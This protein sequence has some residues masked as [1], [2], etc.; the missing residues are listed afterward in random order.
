MKEYVE[1]LDGVSA[2]GAETITQGEISVRTGNLMFLYTYG[3]LMSRGPLE[4]Y[5]MFACPRGGGPKVKDGHHVSTQSLW[6]P[7]G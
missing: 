7:Y 4:G 2:R 3:F 5:H 6:G 1:D